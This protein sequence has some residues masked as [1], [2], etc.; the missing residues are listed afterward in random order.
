MLTPYT[1]T[2]TDAAARR[3]IRV[4]FI[5]ADPD[6]PIFDLSK[7]GATVRCFNALTDRVGTATYHLVNNKRACHD[8]LARQR[9]PVPAQTV[10]ED[11]HH[12]RALDFL[13]AHAPVVVK[14]CMQWGGRG[15]SMGV[16]TP[17][18]LHAAVRFARR[19]EPDV[20]L[21]ETV[22]GD[23]LR[24]ILVGG[25]LAAAIRRSPAA[26]TGD[27]VRTLRQLILRRNAA[28]RKEDP[29]NV[30]PWD[31]ET[32]R[33]LAE[34]GRRP[35]EVPAKGERV[36]VRLTNNYHTGGSVEVVTDA[37][38]ARALRIAQRIVRGLEL[39]LAGVDFL[40]D[41]ATRRLTVI[42]VSPDMAISPP[43]GE[44]VAKRFLDFL[45][46]ERPRRTGHPRGGAAKKQRG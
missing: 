14:P 2:L 23:D 15:V 40:I 37:V 42:E 10:Y 8:W 29:S 6:L 30:I 34:L 35:D 1:T 5:N 27:G 28:R 39:P 36:R 9:I 24:V 46:R 19:F 12:A 45:F 32:R 13:R 41:R 16:R 20:L 17:A 44:T 33:N 11:A 4:T 31:A 7:N 22:P 43:E 26:V 38:P 18:D 25:E 21:E 3:G